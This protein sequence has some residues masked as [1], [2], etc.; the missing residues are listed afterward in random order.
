MCHIHLQC[1]PWWV[2]Q[3]DGSH[4]PLT[5]SAS[6]EDRANRVKSEVI[7]I[8]AI[9]KAVCYDEGATGLAQGTIMPSDRLRD[10][11]A[12]ALRCRERHHGRH[13]RHHAGACLTV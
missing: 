11:R 13:Q 1:R 9:A 10:L 3:V 4:H 8:G 7:A 2:S 12:G 6:A 5:S